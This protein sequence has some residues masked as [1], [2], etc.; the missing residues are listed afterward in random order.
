VRGVGLRTIGVIALGA[1]VLAAVL[2]VATTVDAR[3]PQVLEIRITQPAGDD[4]QLALTTT[5]IEVTFNEPVVTNAAQRAFE[6]EPRVTGAISW[7]GP[8]LTFTPDEPLPL[9]T[10]FVVTIAAGVSDPA[11]N[12]MAEPSEPFNFETA[13]RP[14]VVASN[15]EDG[16]TGV[17]LGGPIELTFSSLMDTASVESALTFT[18]AFAHELRWTGQTLTI[19]PTSE[20]EPDRRY[21]VRLADRAS[22]IAGVG[23]EREWELSFRTVSSALRPSVVVPADGTDGIA[24]TTPIAL[25]FDEPIDPESAS[26]ELVTVSPEV[27]GS[28]EVVDSPNG[29]A[30]G[31]LRFTP[32]APLPANTTFSVSLAPGLRSAD[33]DLLAVPTDWSFTTGSPFSTLSNQ[34]IYLSD[35]AGISNLWAMNAD[36]TGRRQ[37]SA[38][39][40][41]ILDYAPAPDGR[42]FIVGDGRQL[43]LQAADGRERRVLTEEGV[44]EFDASYA[45]DGRSIVFGRADAATGRGLGIWVRDA[46]GSDPEPLRLPN[47]LLP[48]PHP[49]ASGESPSPA[50]AGLQRAPRLAPDGDAVAF[51]D[52]E[53]RLV[54]ADLTSEGWVRANLNVAGP[55]IWLSDASG[56]LTGTTREPLVEN[57]SEATI[58]PLDAADAQDPGVLELVVVDRD[59]G[60]VRPT[61]F[62]PGAIRP[63]IAA[64]GSVAYI[65]IDDGRVRD[66]DALTGAL[67]EAPGIDREARP[68]TATRNLDVAWVTSAPEPRGLVISVVDE[69]TAAIWL[70]ELDRG[71]LSPLSDD[72]RR[73]RW[74]P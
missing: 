45:A 4:P 74:L 70:L 6:I 7:S 36:G 5:S 10:G 64:D 32:S 3:A 13:G 67:M 8:T 37:L 66:P 47:D 1:A 18:P 55:P 57:S 60:E 2:F 50:V 68:V 17:P 22:D 33:G 40:S 63:A 12:R 52:A 71:A 39:L 27:P 25:L 59:D 23:L 48:T 43:V 20:L 61:L 24:L 56:V 54:I 51:V 15:P 46:D 19:V 42:T 49:S 26:S 58:G 29:P 53:G 62:G 28:V 34:V 38:E 72:G 41:P 35:R 30:A 73:A 31:V 11:G 44:I 65:Q 9:E 69:P 16:A 14:Q 21:Q